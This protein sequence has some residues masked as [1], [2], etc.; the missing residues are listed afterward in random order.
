MNIKFDDEFVLAKYREYANEENRL[1]G[2]NFCDIP[3]EVILGITKQLFEYAQSST[4]PRAFNDY[5]P[6]RKAPANP[7]PESVG[8]HTNLLLAIVRRYLYLLYDPSET[9]CTD[10]GFS[11]LEV[12]EAASRHDL[13]ENEIGD[14]LD[15]RNRDDKGLAPIENAYWHRLSNWSLPQWVLS[16]PNINRLLYDMRDKHKT[17]TGSFL[18]A[19]D[20]FCSLFIVLVYDALDKPMFLH[21]D[22]PRA[23]EEDREE[24]R[25]CEYVKN[26][27]RKAS[28]MWA[29]GFFQTR[30]T[31]RYDYHGI[32]IRIL[33]M[34]T[35]MVNGEWHEWR[36]AD[37]HKDQ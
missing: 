11:F 21:I 19:A 34:A 33:L 6:G 22:D 28:E 13:P 32:L 5:N 1:S 10:D 4:V 2:Y 17:A 23:S 8:G 25:R 36:I 9:Q 26:G 31:Y 14:Q 37:Y 18:Y 7:T 15:N 29:I 35:L 16:E 30:G 24:M 27:F 20:K 3:A 12:E